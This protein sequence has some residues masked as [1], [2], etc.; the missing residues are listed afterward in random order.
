MV[1]LPPLNATVATALLTN[2]V[3]D[4]VALLSVAIQ[5]LPS[6][7]EQLAR[8]IQLNGP[9]VALLDD[10]VFTM[11]T[12]AGNLTLGAS[13]LPNGTTNP[14]AS[15][16]APMAQS[17][18]P[19]GLILQP[20]S[21]PT[22]AFLLVPPS[23]M[24]PFAGG[25]SAAPL[26]A[27]AQG[28]KPSGPPI[29]P[30][31]TLSAVVL[32]GDFG[33]VPEPSTKLATTSSGGTA[34]ATQ[35][36]PKA[37]S[38]TA[39]AQTPSVTT[40]AVVKTGPANVNLQSF[41]AELRLRVDSVVA[42]NAL[43]PVPET[44][45]QFVATVVGKGGHGGLL[46]RVEG[47]SLFVRQSADLPTGSRLLLSV[48]PSEEAAAIAWPINPDDSAPS[49]QKLMAA[50]QQLD[51]ALAQQV[52]HTRV[53]QAN[54]ALPGSMLFL[55]NVLQQSGVTGWLGEEATGKLDKDGKRELIAKL[56][57]ELQQA[58]A[59]ARD[60]TVGEWRAFPFP[61]IDQGQFQMLRLYVHRDGQQRQ[62]S[63]AGAELAKQTRFLISMNMSRLGAMQ[64]D[65]LAR[66]RQLELVVRSER[67]LPHGLPEELR[68]LYVHTLEALGLTG[69]INFQTGRQ[70]WLV[71]QREG[72]AAEVVT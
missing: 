41:G 59:P 49:L 54:A 26:V 72:G 20:G 63:L 68:G 30:G 27:F 9:I 55:F 21:P 17:Q 36:L 14:L 33:R 15:F 45:D 46:L 22:Q 31:L 10:G 37:I 7:L 39:V 65:G 29:A 67:P 44:A 43:A 53:P 58:S 48:L 28:L 23:V 40:G 3:P 4:E 6:K 19:V 71:V 47:T 25:S 2:A 66:P 32:P 12:A 8:A 11:Q 1:D 18:R 62:S 42:P 34:P 5:S 38:S 35:A 69:S 57:D 16:L 24:E 51:P 64:M 50:L 60:T 13:P 70:N 52:L 56:I 61:I